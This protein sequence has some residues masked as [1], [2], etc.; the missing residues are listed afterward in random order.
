MPEDSCSST[1][2]RPRKWSTQGKYLNAS[3]R[4]QRFY[5]FR[6]EKVVET[7]GVFTETRRRRVERWWNGTLRTRWA[8]WEEI[9]PRVK[10][11]T[12]YIL[13]ISLVKHSCL[14][15]YHLDPAVNFPQ[16]RLE[17]LRKQCGPHVTAVAKDS[18]EGICSKIY[19]ISAEYVRRIRQSHLKLLKDCNISGMFSLL[20]K[21]VICCALIGQFN[22]V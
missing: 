10:R 7:N 13:N 11:T 20:V 17:H 4:S 15:A 5:Q 2:R 12:W 18:V 16:D 9:T 6:H 1:L 8:G 21:G 22:S 3:K 14:S 19:H